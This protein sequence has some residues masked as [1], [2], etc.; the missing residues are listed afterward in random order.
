MHELDELLRLVRKFKTDNGV[1]DQE[2]HVITTIHLMNAHRIDLSAAQD[3]TS[4]GAGDK[5]IDGWHFDKRSGT[6]YVYQSKLSP[7]KGTVLRGFEGLIEASEW[8]ACVLQTGEVGGKL[9]N[10]AVYNLAKCLHENRRMTRVVRFSLLS[11][12]NENELL[13]S[14]EFNVSRDLLVKSALNAYVS[15]HEGRL[16]LQAEEYNLT[17]GLPPGYSSYEVSGLND[18]T[19]CLGSRTQLHVVYL[20]LASLVELFRRRGNRLFEK[21]IRLFLSTKESRVRLEHPLEDTLERIC[22]GGLDPAIF[23]FY[24]VGITLTARDCK[25]PGNGVYLLE[26]PNVINGCQTINIADRYL[27]KLEKE[28]AEGKIDRFRAVPVLAK[29]VIAANEDQQREI[30]N[31]NNRQNPIE[32]WQLFSNDPIH[33]E[34]EEAFRAKGVFYERQKGK[35][36]AEMKSAEN[37][38]RYFNTNNTKITVQD[39]GQLIALCRREVQLAAKPSDIYAS[40]QVHDKVFDRTIPDR[41]I[42]DSIWAFNAFKAVKKG[43]VNYLRL[44]T[45]ENDERTHA[46]FVKPLVKHVLFYAA[47]MHLYQ[48]CPGLAGRYGRKLNKK[49]PS[50]LI[51]ESESFYRKVVS[52]TKNWYLAES[53]QLQYEV[54][55]NKLSSFLDERLCHESGLDSEGIMPFTAASIDWSEF[56]EADDAEAE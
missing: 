43:L 20:H 26:T 10:P 30:A 29:I 38:S 53:Q 55:Y 18:G 54:S 16:D 42:Q 7:N 51:E 22:A 32:S 46:I 35:F 34:I 6:L 48:R 23:P 31:C 15:E 24:H 36:D 9:S 14:S 52:K 21:N 3:Q 19:V 50:G 1:Q 47:L 8:I 49:S 39:L 56:T 33:I 45:H 44:P 13:D 27:K 37:I 17:G 12:F 25:R 11:L 41:H 4:H 40:K 2:E 5:G 28:K